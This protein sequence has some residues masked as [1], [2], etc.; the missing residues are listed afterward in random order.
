MRCDHVHQQPQAESSPY[1]S[2]RYR[3]G[4]EKKK[5]ERGEP[6]PAKRHQDKRRKEKKHPEGCRER[7]WRKIVQC[8]NPLE[9]ESSQ[10]FLMNLFRKFRDISLHSLGYHEKSEQCEM[11]YFP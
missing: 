4:L 1:G 5:P 6:A 2:A 10:N 9:A 8:V 7:L 3:E 11:R